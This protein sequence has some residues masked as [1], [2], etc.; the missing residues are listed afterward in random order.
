MICDVSLKT[1]TRCAD[2][3]SIPIATTDPNELFHSDDIDI[4]FVLTLDE[5]HAPLTVAALQ[6]EKFVMVEKPITSSLQSCEEIPEAGRTAPNGARVFVGY[7]RRYAPTLSV[8]KREISTIESIKYA[9]VRDIIR[10]NSY[11]IGQSGCYPAK[12]HDDISANA[13]Q[14]RTGRVEKLFAEA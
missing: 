11:F 13:R 6:A 2:K 3:F 12:F 10:P 9:T 7:M 8:F 14:E 5:F 4:I 1:A